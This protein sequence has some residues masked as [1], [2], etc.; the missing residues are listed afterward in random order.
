MLREKRWMTA[1][2]SEGRDTSPRFVH[3]KAPPAGGAAG[4]RRRMA[5]FVA[6]LLGRF[7]DP[8]DETEFGKQLDRSLSDNLT[9]LGVVFGL[10]VILFSAW[11]YWI[12]P[13]QTA[14]TATVRLSLVLVGAL[15]YTGWRD[16]IPVVW[17]YGVVYGTHTSAMILSS[18]LLPGG[19]VLA[20]P[21]ITGA[22]FPL[23]LVEPRLHR[24]LLIVLF[25][26]LL[27]VVLAA[28]VL[29]QEAFVSSVL[30]YLVT[31][32]LVA[33]VALSQGR[34]R[35]AAFLAERA[36]A[37]AAYHDSLSGVLARGRL[38]EL[39]NHDVALA[40]RYG[41]PLAIGMVDI[42][43]FKCVNDNFGHAA[44]DELL[45]AVSQVC[46][47]QLRASDY[48]GRIGGEEFVCVMPETREVDALACAER[49]RTAVAAI[50]IETP[51]G[52]L[53]CTISIGVATLQGDADFDALLAAADAAMY[54][55]KSTGRNRVE[56]APCQP[57][58]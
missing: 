32:A 33:A 10:G 46:S 12:A 23:A 42:D 55:A 41:R 50:R 21:A 49:M 7:D 15:G 58:G 4:M 26:S 38:V 45:R 8:V 29:P 51:A 27:F 14:T 35:R 18:A 16:R 47:A 30:V 13:Q 11:D 44:G 52:P 6:R 39:A 3:E 37:Y 19:L 40:K 53:R 17:R 2:S 54:R 25:P 43:H 20:L 5:G 36:L 22:M 57:S 9:A 34:G 1:T 31:M 28:Q 24:L 48:F 56:L